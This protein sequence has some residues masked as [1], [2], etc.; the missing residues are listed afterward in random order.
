MFSAF[1]AAFLIFSGFFV[2][3]GLVIYAT[4]ERVG[5]WKLLRPK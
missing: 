5:V 2:V 3:L 4:L 1:L